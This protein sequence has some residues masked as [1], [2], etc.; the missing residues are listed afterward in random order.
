MYLVLFLFYVSLFTHSSKS[1]LKPD[2]SVTFFGSFRMC[3]LGVSFI[4][5]FRKKT[6]ESTVIFL[7]S[8]VLN[9]NWKENKMAGA[10]C[11]E[12]MIPRKKNKEFC[13]ESP[14]KNLWR[15]FYCG[16]KLFYYGKK[17]KHFWV[18]QYIRSLHNA[19]LG[20]GKKSL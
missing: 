10:I 17:Q 11:F 3:Y 16:K 2:Y 19:I 18:C 4:F 15:L 9:L 13:T 7:W 5:H 6:T 20:T 1:E 8:G 14:I 12:I